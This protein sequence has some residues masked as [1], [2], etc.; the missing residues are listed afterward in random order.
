MAMKKPVAALAEGGVPEV[1]EHDKSGLLSA[2]L[3]NQAL[4]DN[5][6]ALL[7]DPARRA[8]MGEFGRKRVLEYFNASRMANEA[9]DAYDAIIG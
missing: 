5:L 2:R 3:D 1:V 9:A 4:A 7:S 6:A 8:A